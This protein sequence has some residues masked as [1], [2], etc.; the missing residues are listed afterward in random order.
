MS[1]SS[2]RA[3]ERRGRG[4]RGQSTIEL[5]VTM[6]VLV[7]LLMSVFNVTVMISDRLVAGYATRQG[8]R[9]AAQVGNGQ[10][11]LTTAQADQLILQSVLASSSNLNFATISEVDIYRPSAADGSY[12]ATDPHNSY[13]GTGAA[14]A[15]T[16][17]YPVANRQVAPPNEDSIGVRI[18][19]SYQPPTGVY[20][21]TVQLS[22]YTVMKAAPVLG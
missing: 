17:A 19:W 21:F 10:G 20:S 5:A 9:Y 13:D 11:I 2:P 8:A 15:G 12:Q 22:E 4:G 1:E 18:I 16:P 6:P 14:I 7:V 3:T